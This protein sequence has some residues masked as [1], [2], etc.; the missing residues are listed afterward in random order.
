MSPAAQNMKTRPDAHGTTESE[1]EGAKHENWTPAPSVP[2][3][4]S[5][6]AQNMKIGPDAI[7]TAQNE[8]GSTKDDNGI[9]HPRCR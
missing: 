7:G 6:A 4:M 3:K 5:P 2:P 1:Y 9:W 8:F